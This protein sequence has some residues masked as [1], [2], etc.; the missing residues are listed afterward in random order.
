MV[1]NGNGRRRIGRAL[2]RIVCTSA[3]VL[4]LLLGTTG[5]GVEMPQSVRDLPQSA[6]EWGSGLTSGLG[7][8]A[9][10]AKDSVIQWWDNQVQGLF[11]GQHDGSSNDSGFTDWLNGLLGGDPDAG[12]TDANGQ[13]GNGDSGSSDAG[14]SIN[15]Q[16]ASPNSGQSQ[17]SQQFG[18][19]QTPMPSGYSYMLFS[20]GSDQPALTISCEPIRYAFSGSVSENERA[21]VKQALDTIT[22]VND[23]QFQEV[24]QVGDGSYQSTGTLPTHTE[25]KFEF[26]TA[27]Q[28][29]DFD[30]NRTQRTLGKAQPRAVSRNNEAPLIYYA[31]IRLNEDYFRTGGDSAQGGQPVAVEVIEH[32]VAHALGLDH[33]DS[34]GSFMNPVAD[35]T[36]QLT[37]TDRQA[38][39]ALV[40]DCAVR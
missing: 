15:G 22:S 20:E 36:P 35:S 11:G 26:L 40:R 38:L 21:M 5:C 3:T 1:G 17:Q 33:S 39:K 23:L 9:N 12:T 28:Y 13:S 18:G 32:E 31:D 14:G 4:A 2:G 30:M 37:D 6:K 10:E 16:S 24:S 25:F 19:I 29:P 27:A 7:D 34:P 8:K